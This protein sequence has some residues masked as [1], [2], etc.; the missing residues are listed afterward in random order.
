[1]LHLVV[2]R[3]HT[4]S[5]APQQLQMVPLIRALSLF[6]VIIAATATTIT[7]FDT[8]LQ[9]DYCLGPTVQLF[10]ANLSLPVDWN[11]PGGEHF[12]LF[13]SKIPARNQDNKIGNLFYNPGGPGEAYSELLLRPERGGYDLWTHSPLTD[14]FD[15][16]AIDPRGTGKSRPV[17]C[18]PKVWQRETRYFPETEDGFD[19]LNAQLEAMGQSCYNE[20][21]EWLRYVD[22]ASTAKDFEAVRIALGGGP[23][24][25]YA[26]SYGTQLAAQYVEL[27]PDNI[28]AV[29]LDS[30][31]DHSNMD[32][33]DNWARE[34]SNYEVVAG[35]FFEWC[36]GAGTSCVLSDLDDLPTWFDNLVDRLNEHPTEFLPPEPCDDPVECGNRVF[37]EQVMVQMA[38]LLAFPNA[39]PG[40]QETAFNLRLLESRGVPGSFGQPLEH[41]GDS[42]QTFSFIAIRCSDAPPNVTKPDYPA[43]RARVDYAKSSFPHTRGNIGAW[44]TLTSCAYW[45]VPSTNPPHE[46]TTFKDGKKK[47]ATPVLIVNAYW[48]PLTRYDGAMELQRQFGDANAVLL[49]RDGFGHLSGQFPGAVTD[50]IFDYLIDLKVPAPGTV[51]RNFGL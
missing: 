16:V 3:V 26:E 21:G 48:D 29:V 50:A 38:S 12:D 10:C 18:D 19:R 15:F 27:F 35:K 49:S 30:V 41:D 11:D 42:S 33:V 36:K 39:G 43:F 51:L 2:T 25:F 5:R 13:I 47:L 23:M 7:G 32:A 22:T 46:I 6:S 9:W 8:D 44:A 31:L 28:R 34:S 24:T 14:R 37:G 17:L 4:L 45:P 40:W 1:M 20:T